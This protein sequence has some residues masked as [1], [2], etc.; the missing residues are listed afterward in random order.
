MCYGEMNTT[1]TLSNCDERIRIIIEAR[2]EA[3]T[4]LS[5]F[6]DLEAR[7]WPTHYLQKDG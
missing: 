2:L 5:S 4:F 6:G 7:T 3:P 1:P